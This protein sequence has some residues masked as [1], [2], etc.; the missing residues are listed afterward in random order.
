MTHGRMKH[1]CA[2]VKSSLHL[3]STI[4]RKRTPAAH[5]SAPAVDS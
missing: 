1:I 5:T 2:F 4:A 3:D